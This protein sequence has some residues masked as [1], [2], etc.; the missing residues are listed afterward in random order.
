MFALEPPKFLLLSSAT[1]SPTSPRSP[2]LTRLWCENNPGKFSNSDE[3]VVLL[4]SR[5]CNVYLSPAYP[6][7]LVR[8]RAQHPNSYYMSYI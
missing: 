3:T 1:R 7:S 4:K 8:V 5:G 2:R 6:V